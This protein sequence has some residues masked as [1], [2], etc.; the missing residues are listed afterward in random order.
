MDQYPPGKRTRVSPIKETQ[1]WKE[2]V[3]KL[4]A[5]NWEVLMV[6]FSPETLELGKATP[7]RFRRMLAAEIKTMKDVPPVR[8]TFRGKS[9]K[10][11][12]PVLY[13]VRRDSED[14]QAELPLKTP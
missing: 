1:D 13:I 12:A 8:L 4:T 10:T 14:T 2:T 9:R 11:G 7:D 5:G 6:E 3:E